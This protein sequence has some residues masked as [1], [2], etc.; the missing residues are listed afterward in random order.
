MKYD[1]SRH[2]SLKA[3]TRSFLGVI[4]SPESSKKKTD[5]ICEISFFC[6]TLTAFNFLNREIQSF[7]QRAKVFLIHKNF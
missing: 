6:L 1:Q 3:L 7:F 5:F 4:L 2:V